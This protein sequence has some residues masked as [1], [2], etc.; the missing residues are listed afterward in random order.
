MALHQHEGH[1]LSIGRG[2]PTMSVL[3]SSE[4][5]VSVHCSAALK[6]PHHDSPLLTAEQKHS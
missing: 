4:T 5:P 6:I 3:D 2:E 1:V